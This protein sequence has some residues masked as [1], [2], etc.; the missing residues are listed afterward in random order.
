MVKI[1][2]LVVLALA[3]TA[4]ASELPLTRE[5]A[6]RVR[7]DVEIHPML[8]PADESSSETQTSRTARIGI[9]ALEAPPEAHLQPSSSLSS[10][11][12]TSPG[13]TRVAFADLANERQAMLTELRDVVAMPHKRLHLRAI[14]IPFTSGMENHQRWMGGS[15][16]PFVVDPRRGDLGWSLHF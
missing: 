4:I 13:D 15:G 10:L 12:F 16:G 5:S 7:A 14:D 1:L 3:M 11:A 9:G 8:P 6:Q 2:S